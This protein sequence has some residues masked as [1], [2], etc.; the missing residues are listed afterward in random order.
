MKALLKKNNNLLYSN[1]I[2]IILFFLLVLMMQW[3]QTKVDNFGC[4]ICADKAGY[5]AYL[6]AA[7]HY[8]FKASAYPKN[9]DHDHG[10]GFILD[11]EKD[12]VITK[13]TCGLALLQVPFYSIGYCIDKIFG[14]NAHPYSKYYLFFINIGL[15]FYVTLGLYCLKKWYSIFTGEKSSLIAVLVI[16]FGSNLLYYTIDESLMSHAYSFSLFSMMLY[17]GDRFLQARKRGY[18]IVYCIAAAI[19]ILIRPTNVVFIPFSWIIQPGWTKNMFEKMKW[20][21]HPLHL[22][23]ATL[24]LLIVLVPQMMYWNFAYEKYLA[25]S[26]KEEGF[27]RWKD[28]A[29]LIVWFSP[30][31]GL[32][33]YTP[34][35]LLSLIAAFVHVSFKRKWI[36]LLLFLTASYICAAWHHP[37]FGCSF[38]KRP[39]IEFYP[40]LMLPIAHIFK[41]Y[42]EMPKISRYLIVTLILVLLYYNVLFTLKFNTCYFGDTWDWNAFGLLLKKIFLFK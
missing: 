28:P 16:L 13:F 11:Y 31:N 7:F 30:K 36:V 10:D 32:F 12:K 14:I 40:I 8:G 2:F 20:V 19:A 22:I 21:L 17:L 4:E 23:I 38:G 25:W 29:L 24:V 9:F 6:P 34:L 3:R 37:W 5:Y 15:S 27:T 39:F 33:T 42:S 1:K 26:Y 35:V 41:G 18:F